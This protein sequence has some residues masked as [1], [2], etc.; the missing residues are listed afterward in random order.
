M[1][2][3]ITQKLSYYATREMSWFRT[4]VSVFTRKILE[5]SIN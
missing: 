1:N 4:K 5:K 2:G 3:E